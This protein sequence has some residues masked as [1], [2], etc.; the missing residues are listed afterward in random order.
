MS[1]VIILKKMFN[2]VRVVF[3][4]KPYFQTLGW[5]SLVLLAP[6][7]PNVNGEGHDYHTMAT[8]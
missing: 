4:K 5:F 7:L 3:I 1:D 6:M 8:N 2:F